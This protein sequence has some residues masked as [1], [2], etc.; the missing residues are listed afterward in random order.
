MRVGPALENLASAFLA[1]LA[2]TEGL[3]S[4]GTRQSA[5]LLTTKAFIRSHLSDP[6]FGRRRCADDLTAC[7]EPASAYPVE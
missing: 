3:V 6:P 5:L 1:D 7:H 2:D 4:P